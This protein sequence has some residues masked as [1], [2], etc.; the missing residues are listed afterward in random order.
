[1]ARFHHFENDSVVYDLVNELQTPLLR[2]H[3][4]YEGV[5][6]FLVEAAKTYFA[7]QF[8]QE[9][10]APSRFN[11]LSSSVVRPRFLL[12]LS[13][14]IDSSVVCGIAVEAVGADAVLPVSMP[15]RSDDLQSPLHAQVVRDHFRISSPGLPYLVNIEPIVAAHAQAMAPLAAALPRLST[16]VNNKESIMRRGNFGSRVRTAV[17][18]DLQRSLRGRILGTVNRTELCQGYGTKHGTPYAYDYGLLNGLYK[19]DI[20]ELG[21]LLKL[22]PIILETAPTT[23][24]F[25]G[26]THEGELGGTIEEQDVVSYL[27][28][29]KRL[30]LDEIVKRYGA[31]AA[32]V[33]ILQKRWEMGEHKRRLNEGQEEAKPRPWLQ[34][35]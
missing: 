35:M 12:G 2:T 9:S 20:Y 19:V 10:V 32:F 17:L 18:Y 16:V 1:M 6:K 34:S 15:A 27:L 24:Y 29:E 4:S 31:D 28:F 13:G 23:G 11:D 8:V 26:Q 30:S 25:E 22:P 5:L 33:Q 7:D 3:G 21:R 14:G